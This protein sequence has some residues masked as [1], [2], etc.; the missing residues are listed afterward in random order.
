MKR[1]PVCNR[2]YSEEAMLFCADDGTQL[3]GAQAASAEASVP[4]SAQPTMVAPPQFTPP[5]PGPSYQ[6]TAKKRKWLAVIA[7]A[8]GLFALP[9][10]LYS[11]SQPL[12]WEFRFRNVHFERLVVSLWGVATLFGT[13]LM[14][15][16]VIAGAIAIVFALRQPSRYG[17]K[18][19][20]V[21]RAGSQRLADGVCRR[22]VRVPADARASSFD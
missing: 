3:V 6:P 1:C 8:L 10:L 7:L 13:L 22:R 19:L 20:A 15:F 9:F 18:A 16:S 12:L 14:I 11:L 17:G 5:P 4:P 2:S 21:D